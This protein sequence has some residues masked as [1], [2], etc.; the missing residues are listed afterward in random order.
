MNRCVACRAAGRNH[1]LYARGDEPHTYHE[2]CNLQKFSLRT[3]RWTVFQARGIEFFEIF[4]THVEMNRASQTWAATRAYFL[5]ARGD[6]PICGLFQA[7][8]WKF[9]LRTWRWTGGEAKMDVLA[10]IFSTHVEMNRT[11][12]QWIIK[13]T[14]FL[15]ARG[16]EPFCFVHFLFNKKFS[17]RTWRWTVSQNRHLPVRDIFSTHVEMNRKCWTSETR[18]LHFL[19]ARGD[20]PIYGAE[21]SI[22][23]IFSL[24]TWRW[25]G[26]RVTVIYR[27]LIFS[28]HV[29]MNRLDKWSQ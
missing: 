20:E 9:S 19:Y 18:I 15:Y 23:E 1:F 6:E 22:F 27:N 28:T 14:H 16:D 3:W 11:I 12:W 17:L 2:E 5:Y 7:T 25:T 29:E 8:S 26:Q 21:R 10:K 4:S 13:N 24:R